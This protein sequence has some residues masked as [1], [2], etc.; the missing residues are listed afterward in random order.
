LRERSWSRPKRRIES[1]RNS[2]ICEAAPS[3]LMGCP[4]WGSKKCQWLRIVWVP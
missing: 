4:A 2:L 1:T 3:V